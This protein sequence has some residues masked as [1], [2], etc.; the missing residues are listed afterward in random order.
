[1]KQLLAVLL[2]FTS[3][4]WAG[5][6]EESSESFHDGHLSERVVDGENFDVDP[7][8]FD[9]FV[10]G[11]SDAQVAVVSVKGM[12]CDFCARGIEKTF[13]RDPDVKKIDVDLNKGKV[14]I[15]FSSDK[16]IDFDDISQKILSNG[17][18]AT[19]LRIF[20]I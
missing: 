9:K 13:K 14:L 20:N 19:G 1:M 12:V 10:E 6:D 8:R 17:Q 15:A 16:K 18:N 2:L 5:T 7:R 4:A 3:H 11:L